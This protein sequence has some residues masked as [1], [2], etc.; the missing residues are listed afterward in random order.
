MAATEVI[1]HDTECGAYAADLEAW[2]ELAARS[3]GP[4]LELGCGTGRIALRLAR[5]GHEVWGIDRSPE[6]VA[7]LEGRARDHQLAVEAIT[8]DIRGLDLGRRFGLVITAMQL[9][10]MVG[11]ERQRRLV[12]ERAAGHLLPSGLF[13]AAILDGAPEDLGGAPAPLPDV[14]EAG[15]RVYSSL[16]LEVAVDDDRLELRRLRQE[17]AGDGDLL[18]SEHSESLW[19]MSASGLEA[20][21]ERAGLSPSERISVPAVDGYVGSV[22]V[23]AERR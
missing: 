16:P 17:V 19:L 23:V 14:R 9:I 15:G 4:I 2:D 8:G 1:W 11:D 5:R 20:E 21:C 18:E 13:A 10:Q 12:L 3:P 7:A 6:L 22:I